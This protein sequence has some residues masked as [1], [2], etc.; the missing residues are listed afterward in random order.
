MLFAHN[1]EFLGG[2]S[3]ILKKLRAFYFVL[4]KERCIFAAWN[5]IS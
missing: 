2:K 3:D 1:K 4:C 5:G